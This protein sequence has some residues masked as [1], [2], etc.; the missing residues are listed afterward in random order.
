MNDAL[1]LQKNGG[2]VGIGVYNPIYTLDVNGTIR[3][4][5]VTTSSDYRIKNNIEPLDDHYIVD[6]LKPVSYVY[7]NNQNEKPVLGFIA[8]EVQ[9]LF[10]HL[11][12]G[13]KDGK[14][15][16]TLYM[17]ELIPIL[18]KEIQQLKKEM[19]VLKGDEKGI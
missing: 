17:M 11:V 16:Q 19:K 3:C 9:Q 10:P 13:E 18:V 6:N 1:I 12:E 8:H 5:S 7:S 14:E 4:T 15:F 2:Y